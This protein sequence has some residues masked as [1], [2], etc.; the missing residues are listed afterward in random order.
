MMM[1]QQ[2]VLNNNSE[3]Q[4][5][6]KLCIAST[7]YA[8]KMVERVKEVIDDLVDAVRLFLNSL[9]E[10]FKPVRE[11]LTLVF[12]EFKDF[13]EEH[14]DF[15]KYMRDYQQSYPPYVDNLKLNTKGFPRPITHCARSRC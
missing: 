14:E 10:V 2:K 15:I 9:A 12:D 11:S 5:K 7:C 4:D 13:I 8:Y 1:E 3:M 6:W